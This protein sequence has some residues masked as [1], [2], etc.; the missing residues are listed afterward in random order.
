MTALFSLVIIVL[1]AVLIIK[2]LIP[3]WA[4]ARVRRKPK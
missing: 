4:V 1:L 3:V 2:D